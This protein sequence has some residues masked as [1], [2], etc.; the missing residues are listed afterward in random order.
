MGLQDPCV[1]WPIVTI[2]KNETKFLITYLFHYEVD[3]DWML[4][5]NMRDDIEMV[6]IVYSLYWLQD[7]EY[8]ILWQSV[9]EAEKTRINQRY[10]R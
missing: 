5:K 8:R 3:L 4:E 9:A 6:N 10:R 7:I 1:L 2:T